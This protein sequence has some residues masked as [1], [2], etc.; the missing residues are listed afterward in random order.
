VRIAAD[1]VRILVGPPAPKGTMLDFLYQY[2]QAESLNGGES[3]YPFF[4][5]RTEAK[6]AGV[7]RPL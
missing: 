6:I 2:R 1:G 4:L 3:Y 7:L 5:E